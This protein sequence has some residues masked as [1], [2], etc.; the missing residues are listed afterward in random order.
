MRA[1]SGVFFLRFLERWRISEDDGGDERGW[2]NE[3]ISK[4]EG[5]GCGVRN[6]MILRNYF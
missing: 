6:G 4:G 5:A 3:F 1:F 2:N